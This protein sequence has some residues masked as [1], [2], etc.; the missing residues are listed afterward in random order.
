MGLG[1]LYKLA[2]ENMR[3]RDAVKPPP[4][5]RVEVSRA[6]VSLYILA[7][8]SLVV[9]ALLSIGCARLAPVPPPNLPPDVAAKFYATYAIKDLDAIRDFANDAASTN[10]PVISVK[11][12]L[13]IVDWHERAVTLVHAVPGGWKATVLQ[14]LE[15]LKSLPANDYARIAPLI[16]ATKAYLMEL[17]P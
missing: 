6:G 10:P 1:D 14:A 4:E 12:L 11:T 9:W 8:A 17:Q 2:P 13:A 16:A 7:V 15:D 3:R 5:L